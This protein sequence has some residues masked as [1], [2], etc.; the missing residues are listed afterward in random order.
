[1]KKIIVCL[2]IVAFL[3]SS[4]GIVSAQ[5]TGRGGFVGFISGC[6]FGLRSSGAYN[7]GKEIHWREWVMLVPFVNWV[8]AIYNGIEGANGITTKDLAARYGATYY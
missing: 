7:E 5:S 4:V 6:C 3:M 1:M 2:L 8:F